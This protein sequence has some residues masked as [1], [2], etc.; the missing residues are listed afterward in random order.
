VRWEDVQEDREQIRL[1]NSGE[2][3]DQVRW[4]KG[5]RKG[6]EGMAGIV[7]LATARVINS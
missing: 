5:H 7:N 6:R 3:P 4:C 1:G 2:A